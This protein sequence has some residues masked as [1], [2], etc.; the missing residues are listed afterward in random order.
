MLSTL[1]VSKS[2][3]REKKLRTVHREDLIPT[4]HSRQGLGQPIP[5]RAS[6][7]KHYNCQSLLTGTGRSLATERATAEIYLAAL[8]FFISRKNQ[9]NF[10]TL[11]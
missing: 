8:R 5:V 3:I 7:K 10:Y 2:Q 4:L 6:H 1:L 9:E 11:C